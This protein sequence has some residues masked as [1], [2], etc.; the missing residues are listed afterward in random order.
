MINNIGNFINRTLSFCQKYF[1]KIPEP[2]DFDKE[3]EEI[4]DWLTKIGGLVGH[5]LENN[6]VDKALKEILTFSS[7]LNQYFQRKQPWKDP[8]GANTL[9]FISINAVRL[10]LAIM[11]EPF[12]PFSAEKIRLQFGIDSCGGDGNDV[13]I[14]KWESLGHMCIK[15]GESLGKV[16]PLFKKIEPTQIQS[17]KQKLE[18]A[19]RNAKV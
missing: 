4:I 3:D 10:I 11:L 16:E 17:Q 2:S 6:E 12:I 5:L 19:I 8:Q 15:P 14:Q 1:D 18:I 7:F 13:H 9:L